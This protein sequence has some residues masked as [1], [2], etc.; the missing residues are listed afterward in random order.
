MKKILLSIAFGLGLVASGYSATISL[1]VQNGTMTN[2][3]TVYNGTVKVQ[4]IVVSS[5]SST[6]NANNVQFIDTITNQFAL[7]STNAYTNTFEYATNLVVSWT[8]YIGTVNSNTVLATVIATNTIGGFT[9]VY[10]VRL[11]ATATTN[12]A[13]IYSGVNYYFNN[14]IWVTNGGGAAANVIITF[15]Q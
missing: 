4:Q 14:G 6:V 13:T 10:P 9:N 7:V 1:Q 2:L 11:V 5:A 12:T 3:L 8:N 15:Q